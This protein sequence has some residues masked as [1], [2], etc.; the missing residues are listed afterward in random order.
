MTRASR[1]VGNV[2]SVVRGQGR[3]S[4]DVQEDGQKTQST[5]SD[6]MVERAQRCRVADSV[7]NSKME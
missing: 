3:Q 7:S 2:P 6:Q 1:T 5:G 4:E